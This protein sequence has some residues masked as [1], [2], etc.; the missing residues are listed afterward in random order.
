MQGFNFSGNNYRRTEQG[1]RLMELDKEK[2]KDCIHGDGEGGC[3]TKFESPFDVFKCD[4]NE[5][6]EEVE[7]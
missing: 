6:F 7:E 1:G 3:I 5:E 4:H 2:C